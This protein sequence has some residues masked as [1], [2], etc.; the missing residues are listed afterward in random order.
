MVG[1]MSAKNGIP[2]ITR[3][4]N[5]SNTTYVYPWLISTIAMS[6]A[7]ILKSTSMH[8]LLCNTYLSTSWTTSLQAYI[9][10]Y[11]PCFY[12]S[13]TNYDEIK[14]CNAPKSNRAELGPM[15]LATKCRGK[16]QK[17][18]SVYQVTLDKVALGVVLHVVS[19]Y[20][21]VPAYAEF[22]V[23]ACCMR[24]VASHAVLLMVGY[25]MTVT[26]CTM[27]CTILGMLL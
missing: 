9:P 18:V 20:I 21:A 16:R 2:K 10:S 3:E 5:Q 27:S 7:T 22:H 4:G 6:K 15:E 17:G 24:S 8:L 19:N 11:V 25:Y 12:T 23:V 26:S 13:C 14:W 1:F